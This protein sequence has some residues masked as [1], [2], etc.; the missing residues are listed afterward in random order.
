MSRVVVYV[1]NQLSGLWPR[2]KL[3]RANIHQIER[4]SAVERP[5]FD[6]CDSDD[7]E[8]KKFEIEHQHHHFS[9]HHKI[10]RQNSYCGSGGDKE[11][12]VS[13][14]YTLDYRLRI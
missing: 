3:L 4:F 7:D 5:I 13:T 10:S 9:D 14:F 11:E 1:H 6:A 8:A 12:K 2:H